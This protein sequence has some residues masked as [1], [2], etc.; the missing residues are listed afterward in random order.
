M[1]NVPPIDIV[2]DEDLSFFLEGSDASRMSLFVSLTPHERHGLHDMHQECNPTIEAFPSISTYDFPTTS[3]FEE[4]VEACN[5]GMTEINNALVKAFQ[6][7]IIWMMDTDSGQYHRQVQH[8][9][10]MCRRPLMFQH[11]PLMF[12]HHPFYVRH[13]HVMASMNL[14]TDYTMTILK[15]AE[16]VSRTYRVS[17][18]DMYVLNVG[19]LLHFIRDVW[20][21]RNVVA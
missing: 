2:D 18:L 10:P 13:T 11:H 4:N 17:P 7:I 6:H 16:S 1:V 3:S 19:D 15:E 9:P 20:D 14:V 12:R 5:M 21:A 8:N